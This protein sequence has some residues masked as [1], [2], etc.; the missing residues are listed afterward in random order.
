MMLIMVMI[1]RI[2]LNIKRIK[3]RIINLLWVEI[4]ICNQIIKLKVNHIIKIWSVLVLKMYKIVQFQCWIIMILSL[5]I[6]IEIHNLRN[7][8]L[9][10]IKY[11]INNKI[12][13][14][15]YH[16]NQSQQ[17]LFLIIIKYNKINKIN[18]NIFQNLIKIINK[19]II[20]VA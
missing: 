16:Q 19:L 10:F 4:L 9:V 13:Y 6:K 15:H 5:L 12:I 14:K 11:K 1:K 17:S 3:L 7:F 18:N 8:Y 20:F 2:I